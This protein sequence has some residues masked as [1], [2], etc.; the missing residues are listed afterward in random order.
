MS[1]HRRSPGFTLIELMIV[2]LVIGILSAIALPSYL[3]QVRKA[4]R[5]DAMDALEKIQMEEAKFRANCPRYAATMV[6]DPDDAECTPGTPTYTILWPYGA[7]GSETSA[8]GYYTI[9][10]ASPSTNVFSATATAVGQQQKDKCKP[11][12]INQDGPVVD[13]PTNYADA[14]C[15]R[16]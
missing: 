5:A 8:E 12:R 7:S 9:N 16:R 11:F 6:D 13:D 14:N 3:D 15:W 2:V 4:R 1:R 10:L